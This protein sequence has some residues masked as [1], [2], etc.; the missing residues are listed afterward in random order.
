MVV[1]LQDFPVF[2]LMLA[3]LLALLL[4]V[5]EA[6]KKGCEIRT[7]VHRYVLIN[8]AVARMLLCF[9]LFLIVALL[10]C[11]FDPL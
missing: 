11:C 8:I 4:I 9:A 7:T 1:L 6:C 10:W 5:V 3:C 2:L